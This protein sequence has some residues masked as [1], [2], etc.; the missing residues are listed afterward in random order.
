MIFVVCH[1]RILYWGEVLDRLVPLLDRA[2][3][4]DRVFGRYGAI[5]RHGQP[6][7]RPRFTLD[8]LPRLSGF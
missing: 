1:F 7:D 2:R 8:N 4:G 5:N 3:D 6:R